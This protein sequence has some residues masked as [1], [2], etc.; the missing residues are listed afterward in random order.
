[1][2]LSVLLALLVPLKKEVCVR[3]REEL[4]GGERKE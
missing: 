2:L 1:V 4:E 3:E